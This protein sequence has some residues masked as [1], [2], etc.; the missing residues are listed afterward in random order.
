VLDQFSETSPQQPLS[1]EFVRE[2]SLMAARSPLQRCHSLLVPVI[3]GDSAQARVVTG[4]IIRSGAI[5]NLVEA[6][7]VAKNQ[8]RW[9]LQV[10]ADHSAEDIQNFVALAAAAMSC[11]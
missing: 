8:S 3:I 2:V 9:R 11:A 10:M 1:V 7:A 4:E 5:V 6:P